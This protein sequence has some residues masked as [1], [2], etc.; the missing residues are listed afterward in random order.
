M[1]ERKSHHVYLCVCVQ[2]HRVN[3]TNYL[4]NF[5]FLFKGS[6]HNKLKRLYNRLDASANYIS[7]PT[8]FINKEAIPVASSHYHGDVR[9]VRIVKLRQI[10]MKLYLETRR[11]AIFGPTRRNSLA[12]VQ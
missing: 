5:D 2:L 7:F 1:E 11:V 6:F 9:I 3:S 12:I 4:N 8:N 10:F